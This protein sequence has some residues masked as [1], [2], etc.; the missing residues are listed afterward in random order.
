MK[1]IFTFLSLVFLTQLQAQNSVMNSTTIANCGSCSGSYTWNTSALLNPTIMISGPG[2]TRD[3]QSTN[4]GF[5]IPSNATITG[6]HVNFSHSHVFT[7]PTALND[8]LVS[9]LKGGMPTGDNKIG[10]TSVYNQT[11]ITSK[12]FGGATDLWNT[13]WTPA[14]INASN[15]GFD[16][17]MH[18]TAVGNLDMAIHQGFIITVY[19]SIASGVTEYQSRQSRVSSAYLYERTLNFKNFE[20]L[21]NPELFIFDLNGKSILK[22]DPTIHTQINLN[23]LTKGVYFVRVTSTQENWTEKI[24]IQ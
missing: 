4:Y 17:K 10:L 2:F 11:I 20:K 18:A 13:T 3:L 6:I 16:L 9:L 1:K 5:S 21:T 14:D 22:V 7:H 12:N 8:T 24:I 19:Y 15:F 23:D